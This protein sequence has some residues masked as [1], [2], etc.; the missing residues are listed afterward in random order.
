ME[1][2]DVM[3]I[4]RI[5]SFV[6]LLI[7]GVSII[8]CGINDNEDTVVAKVNGEKITKGEFNKLYDQVKQNYY[9]TE[10]IENDPEQKE[11]IAEIKADILEQLIVQ[12]L[13]VQKA[14]DAGFV[15]TDEILDQ[16]RTEFENIIAEVASQME[17]MDN[18]MQD[19]QEEDTEDQG[20][21]YVGEAR[22]FVEEQLDA[23][24]Q[25]EDEY[26]ELIAQQIV[27]DNYVE[28]LV[29]DVNANEQEIQE[30][31]EERLQIQKENISILAFEE[32]ELY[33]PEEV[34][35][36]HVLIKLPQEDIDQYNAMVDEGKT[37]EADKYLDEKLKAIEPKAMEVLEK[38]QNGQ[39]FEKLIEEYGEDPGMEDNDVG[40]IVR[41]DGSFV[42]QFEEAAFSLE[43]GEISDLV[44][45]SYGYHIIKL[46]EKMPEKLY[47]LEEKYD[48]LE[49]VVSQHK[50]IDAWTV[51][52]DEWMEKAEIKRYEGRL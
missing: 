43:E 7:L 51:M 34:R 14:K 15:V 26:I 50:K 30:Y 47:T 46:Y 42:P 48:E 29:K 21:D 38:A 5:V 49:Q 35:V 32:V 44:A 31:Y 1:G 36:K 17:I 12:K 4:K 3:I 16:A 22:A 39:E 19:E 52:L 25:T 23:M 37:E 33:S 41:Q 28:E 45:S 6:L 27:I 9:I 18:N 24:G 11:T 8:G 40:Y 10:E 2:I 20:K 13:I